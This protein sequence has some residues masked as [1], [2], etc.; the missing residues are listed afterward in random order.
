[1][2]TYHFHLDDNDYHN[3]ELK[4]ETNAISNSNS[5]LLDTLVVR[6]HQMKCIQKEAIALFEKKNKDYGDTFAQHGSIGVMIRMNDKINR[7]LSVKKRSIEYVKTETLRDT[8]ID[9]YN[10]TAMAIMLLDEQNQNQNQNNEIN[11]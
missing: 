2:E 3:E 6:M 4:P 10:Y 8:L 7:Y 9:L 1:M 5:N 11:I